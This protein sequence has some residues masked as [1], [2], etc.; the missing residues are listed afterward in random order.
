MK[1]AIRDINLSKMLLLITK[2]FYCS[3]PQSQQKFAH[4]TVYATNIIARYCN[5]LCDVISKC[6]QYDDIFVPVEAQIS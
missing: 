2:R 3:I 6:F 5:I 4:Y 1:E